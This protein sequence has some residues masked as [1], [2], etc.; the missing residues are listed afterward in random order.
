VLRNV[1]DQVEVP[2]EERNNA[3]RPR[4]KIAL[5]VGIAVVAAAALLGAG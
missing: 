3:E 2:P 1:A 5:Y 4:S